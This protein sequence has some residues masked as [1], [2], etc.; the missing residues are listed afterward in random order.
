LEL[1]HSGICHIKQLGTT[2]WT[3]TE[4][5]YETMVQGISKAEMGEVEKIGQHLKAAS[6]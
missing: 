5:Y 3:S 2:T 4:I 1:I 6:P